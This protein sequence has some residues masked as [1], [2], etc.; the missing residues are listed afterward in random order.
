MEE[1]LRRTEVDRLQEQG[2]AELELDERRR[3][4]ERLQHE[5]EMMKAEAQQ[6]G[7]RSPGAGSSMVCCQV[8]RW[9]VVHSSSQIVS[10]CDRS[11]PGGSAS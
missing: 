3:M 11:P 5:A 8:T 4:L 10:F 1:R 2:A 9:A 6:V 7:S